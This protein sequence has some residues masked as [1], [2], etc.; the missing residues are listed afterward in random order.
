MEF[1]PKQISTAVKADPSKKLKII[2]DIARARSQ[3]LGSKRAASNYCFYSG[4]ARS[5]WQISLK[6]KKLLVDGWKKGKKDI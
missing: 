5:T 2:N 6:S 4:V 3:R 1:P